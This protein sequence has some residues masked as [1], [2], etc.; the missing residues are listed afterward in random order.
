MATPCEL[1]GKPRGPEFRR[2]QVRFAL[3]TL[4]NGQND[5]HTSAATKVG[6]VRRAS[7][8]KAGLSLDA[9][10]PNDFTLAQEEMRSAAASQKDR[11]M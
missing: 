3:T 5:R 11:G 4:I 6:G 7:Y 2:Q 10:H 1:P 9:S 8:G